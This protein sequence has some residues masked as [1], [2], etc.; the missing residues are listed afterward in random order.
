MSRDNPDPTRLTTLRFLTVL[1]VVFVATLPV[2]PAATAGFH[3]G[4]NRGEIECVQR[5]DPWGWWD[6]V[7]VAVGDCLAVSY[8]A[9]SNEAPP[10]EAWLV[11]AA[12]YCWYPNTIQP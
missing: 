7:S 11:Y 5:P 10:S 9:W 2:L 4:V 1:A 8:A 3:D 12:I 6:C